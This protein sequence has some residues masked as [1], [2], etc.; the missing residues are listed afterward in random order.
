M[1]KV[2]YIFNSNILTKKTAENHLGDF[3]E[4]DLL[5]LYDKG[6]PIPADR[7]NGADSIDKDKGIFVNA[8]GSYVLK[9]ASIKMKLGDAV[10]TP[11]QDGYMVIPVVNPTADGDIGLI[12]L[13]NNGKIPTALINVNA[14]FGTGA[15]G[16]GLYVVKATYS[17]LN[18][19]SQNYK[20]VVSSNKLLALKAAL[21][22]TLTSS[23]SNTV[24]TDAEKGTM[25]NALGAVGTTVLHFLSEGE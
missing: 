2:D 25:R 11:G 8:D 4:G 10:L 23:T 14:N 6:V 22:V 18:N 12:G 17:D 7:V 9:E 21:G 5:L 13:D 19:S 1:A 24:I 16:S 20:P 3:A 15:V